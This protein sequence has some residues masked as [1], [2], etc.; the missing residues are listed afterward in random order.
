MKAKVKKAGLFLLTLLALTISFPASAIAA[1][2]GV[3]MEVSGYEELG[4]DYKDLSVSN[5]T[6]TLDAKSVEQNLDAYF[7]TN[8]PT[9][10]TMLNDA[11]VFY[12]YKMKRNGND[13][14]SVGDPLPFAGKFKVWV[15][16][17]NDPAEMVPRT[18]DVSELKNYEYDMPVLLKGCNITLSE[19]GYYYVMLM[20]EAIAGASEVLIQVEGDNPGAASQSDT[21]AAPNTEVSAKSTSSKVFVNGTQISFDAYNI[22]G[23]NYFKLRDLAKAIGG[24]EKQF[25]VQWNSGVKAIE[26][27]S[28]QSY[29]AVGGELSKGDGKTKNAT[30]N[31][32]KIYKDGG[33]IS[34]T[35]YNINGNN[36]FKL[37]DIAN[38]FNI[39][40]TWDS[41]TNTVGIDTAQPYAAD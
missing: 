31:T 19:P 25:E 34:L 30:L 28:N 14:Q 23:N 5:V 37:R 4:P 17:Q 6:K 9:V 26:L 11:A 18:L 36:Y 7:V 2:A 12:I 1:E 3:T 38:A 10:V 40:I 16:G 20:Y 24:T 22:N 15:A 13:Y 21:P 32:S 35:A 41:K 27:V 29:T 39:G 8:S 33:E